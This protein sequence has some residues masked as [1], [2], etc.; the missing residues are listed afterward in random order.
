MGWRTAG[1]PGFSLAEGARGLVDDRVQHLDRVAALEGCHARRHLVEQDAQAEDVGAVVHHRG[2]RRLLGARVAHRAV[3][4]ADLGH[5]VVEA[6][7][8]RLA[9]FAREGLH[10][11]Q[12]EVEH[13]GLALGGD[14]DVRGLQV[15]VH[16]AVGVGH[17]QRVGDLDGDGQGGQRLERPARR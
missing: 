5:G 11:G 13:L 14:D 12:A 9:V 4:H 3:G 1:A 17:R 7:R 2:A 16:D 6:R 15:A 10:L 8:R